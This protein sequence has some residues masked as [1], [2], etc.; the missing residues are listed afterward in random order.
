MPLTVLE[1]QID[2]VGSLESKIKV[3]YKR[4]IDLLE[5]VDLRYDKFSLF[6]ED[7]LFLLEC[8]QSIVFIV[9]K[10]LAEKDLTE[11]TLT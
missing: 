3:Y 2:V 1:T 5:D 4:V 9:F 7:N 11:R 8:F 6:A 10:A